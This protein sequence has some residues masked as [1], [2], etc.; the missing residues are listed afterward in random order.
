MIKADLKNNDLLEKM[1]I[2]TL[3][4]VSVFGI[5]N[6]LVLILYLD[7]KY[8]INSRKEL[9]I[10]RLIILFILT[11]IIVLN[12]VIKTN[13]DVYS[14][15]KVFLILMAITINIVLTNTNS[16]P[17]FTRTWVI[18]MIFITLCIP[19]RVK[20]TA[21]LFI[22]LFPGYIMI[23]N[24]LFTKVNK[25][26]NL[27][28]LISILIYGSI[29]LF[30]KYIGIL[31]LDSLQDG[32]IF[33]CSN[34]ESFS[35]FVSKYKLS[36]HQAEI[37]SLMFNG[38]VTHQGIADKLNKS[39]SNISSTLYRIYDKV[40]VSNQAELLLNLKDIYFE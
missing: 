31:V 19:L 22:I 25:I 10:L 37:I 35:D 23:H 28:F 38:E 8:F 3:I 24:I 17:Y 7:Y 34:K 29:F 26:I 11:I 6:Q 4:F 9:L 39:R 13:I 1:I 30:L 36:K 40:G 16:T 5:L 15:C 21:L 20:Q 2:K 12:K 14:Q 18:Y 27:G 32:D 33:N